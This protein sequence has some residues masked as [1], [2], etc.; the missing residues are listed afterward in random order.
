MHVKLL[1]LQVVLSYM[2][3][4]QCHKHLELQIIVNQAFQLDI[5]F[6]NLPQLIAVLIV[7]L[8]FRLLHKYLVILVLY[9]FWSLFV[10]L[11]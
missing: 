3:R 10:M 1:V 5:L 6:E 4:L 2:L 9:L 7:E 11:L 8:A